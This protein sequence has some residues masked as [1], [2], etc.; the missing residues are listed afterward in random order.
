MRTGS[1]H[2]V[3]I[4]LILVGFVASTARA[5]PIER[6]LASLPIEAIGY[7]DALARVERVPEL[8][9]RVDAARGLQLASTRVS[10]LPSDLVLS[11]EAGPRVTPDRDVQGR[12]GVSQSFALAGLGGARREV[13]HGEAA[14]L[15]AERAAALF[16]RRVEVARAWLEVHYAQQAVAVA[17]NELG[18]AE[19][20][21]RV[22]ARGAELSELT[23]ADAADAQGY[24]AEARLN[25]LSAQGLLIDARYQLTRALG[26]SDRV[27]D[28]GGETPELEVP[29][30]SRVAALNARLER[31]PALAALVMQVAV[32]HARM[33]ELGAEHASQ[34]AVGAIADRT[35]P[36]GFAVLG[37]LSFTLPWEGRLARDRADLEASQAVLDGRLAA[38]R[39]RGHV[40]L[41]RLAH[42]IEHAREVLEQA[43]TK[44]LPAIGAG[45]AAREALF[46]AGEGNALEL[47][48]ARRSALSLRVRRERLRTD[49]LFALARFAELSRALGVVP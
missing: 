4:A 44:L 39:T 9:A 16:E 25:F 24:A 48:L 40:E 17:G 6:T 10:S 45:L 21:A 18:L 43:E 38:E 30:A 41:D 13:L 8:N 2:G 31:S 22:T 35:D 7:E 46:R 27:L 15:D 32:V 20:L 5:Q 19:D 28:A 34:I 33:R 14:A 36:R 23:R 26:V 47:I 1:N 12:I 49:L 11:A 37:M 42:E 3:S 29:S